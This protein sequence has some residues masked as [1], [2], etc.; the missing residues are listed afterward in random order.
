[1]SEDI[2]RM[3]ND[4][5]EADILPELPAATAPLVTTATNVPA[6]TSDPIF[7]DEELLGLCDEVL[8]NIRSDRKQLDSILC[9]FVEMVFNEGDSTTAS[10]EALVSMMTAKTN[11]ND[12]M[13][14]V[15]SLVAQFKLKEAVVPEKP[16]TLSATQENHYYFGGSRRSLLEKIDKMQKKNKKKSETEEKP[17]E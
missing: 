12:K 14:K 16:K 5:I 17:N 8:G 11:M 4:V 7:Q 2:E 10:K 13:M 9:N 3:I 1:M 15:V 6:T